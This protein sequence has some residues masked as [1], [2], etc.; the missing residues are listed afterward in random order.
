MKK[1]VKDGGTMNYEKMKEA[2][3][4][5]SGGIALMDNVLTQEQVDARD[6]LTD[7][8]EQEWSQHADDNYSPSEALSVASS[9]T[10]IHPGKA[11]EQSFVETSKA[12]RSHLA[13]MDLDDCSSFTFSAIATGRVLGGELKIV[14][15]LNDYPTQVNGHSVW[16]VVNE[17]CR[18]KGW[19]QLNAPLMISN[20]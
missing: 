1:I 8:F 19:A 2:W 6:I 12:V 7:G 13:S 15:N 17:F 14:F 4:V 5:L 20:A 10:T 11:F 16:P 9:I 3:E 18:Q